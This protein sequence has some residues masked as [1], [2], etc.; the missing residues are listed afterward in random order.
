MFLKKSDADK[1]KSLSD[2]FRIIQA[3]LTSVP[4]MLLNVITLIN[5]LKVEGYEVLDI[6]YLSQHLSEGKNYTITQFENTSTKLILNAL[7]TL[8][9]MIK[10]LIFSVRMH[11]FAFIVSFINLLRASSL[12]NE[13]ESFTLLFVL[14]GCPFL[15]LTA[16]SRILSLGIIIAFLDVT[17][18]TIL[19]LG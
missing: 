13:R 17:W 9:I 6:S 7:I 12:Y 14:V 15:L 18:I 1:A 5:A 2:K 16:L 3:F 11:G 19:I 10:Y 8:K 4:L